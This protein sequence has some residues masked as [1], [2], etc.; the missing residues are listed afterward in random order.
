MFKPS[1]SDLV[2]EYTKQSKAFDR[3]PEVGLPACVVPGGYPIV[4]FDE[5]GNVL[6]AD[7]ASKSI[8]IF[9]RAGTCP[10]ARERAYF[11]A[12]VTDWMVFYEGASMFCDECNTEIE[13]AYG[14]PEMEEN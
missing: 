14:D 10:E 7:C 1:V 3:E 9:A 6:C 8:R 13:S 2:T 11:E 4:Y 5:F 12:K